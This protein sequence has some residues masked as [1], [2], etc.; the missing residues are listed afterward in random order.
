[1]AAG[2]CSRRGNCAGAGNGW[3]DPGLLPGGALAGELLWA[4]GVRVNPFS[5]FGKL[6]PMKKDSLGLSVNDWFKL[7]LRRDDVV[8]KLTSR[9]L[10]ATVVAA[11]I[12]AFGQGIGL[13]EGA[14]TTIV[15]LVTKYI[16]AQAAVDAA[17][18]VAGG[19]KKPE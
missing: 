15:G 6:N 11:T 5:I 14:I 8:S 7:W 1:M 17:A 13:P 2:V 18:Q 19:L 10:W 4:A 16:L 9:K 3:A 12:A